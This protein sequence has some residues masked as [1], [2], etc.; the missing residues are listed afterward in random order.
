ML[1]NNGVVGSHF[2]TCFFPSFLL[3]VPGRHHSFVS[4]EQVY[5]GKGHDGHNHDGQ[6]QSYLSMRG[7][8]LYKLSALSARARFETWNAGRY[9]TMYSGSGSRDA[10]EGRANAG[11]SAGRRTRRGQRRA[12]RRARL[13]SPDGRTRLSPDN[14]VADDGSFVFVPSSS[15][16]SSL[17]NGPPRPVPCRP[18]M[19]PS[20][21]LASRHAGMR[22]FTSALPN[23]GETRQSPWLARVERSFLV[24]PA[25]SALAILPL[26]RG[27][28][29]PHVDGGHGAGTRPL[30]GKSAVPQ[31]I[32][33][34][35]A[36]RVS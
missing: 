24:Q 14:K 7:F 23:S 22:F 8:G 18:N 16:F 27:A 15:S 3:S 11:R 26:C 4:N 34:D 20:C 1:R 32:G 17:S 6:E 5:G 10:T 9:Q 28:V 21:P 13:G 29:P 35:V 31:F 25:W 2:P 33:S 12:L 30:S 19:V 36:G